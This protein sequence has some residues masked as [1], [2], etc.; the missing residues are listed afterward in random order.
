M[1]TFTTRVAALIKL[2]TKRILEKAIGAFL[3]SKAE[4]ELSKH[5]TVGKTSSVR[6]EYYLH[7]IPIHRPTSAMQKQI[8]NE[9]KL[10]DFIKSQQRQAHKILEM[11]PLVDTEGFFGHCYM[12]DKSSPHL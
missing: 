12:E 2:P 9:A 10:R 3:R 8:T 4:G 5:L 11:I 6:I 7:K 1:N